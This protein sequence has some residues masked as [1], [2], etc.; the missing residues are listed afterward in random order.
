MKLKEFYRDYR[1]KA[2]GEDFITIYYE[3]ETRRGPYKTYINE[4]EIKKAA[5][6]YEANG[7]EGLGLLM[8]ADLLKTNIYDTE[9]GY[10]GLDGRSGGGFKCKQWSAQL[11]ED[12]AKI[13]LG[14]YKPKPT[15]PNAARKP[16]PTAKRKRF[17]L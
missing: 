13:A 14:F 8:E 6:A 12:E 2:R 17:T 16:R 5:K 9:G 10:I 15:R 3:T 1:A 7:A 11:D 4:T